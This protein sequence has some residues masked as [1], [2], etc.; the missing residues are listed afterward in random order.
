MGF[1]GDFTVGEVSEMDRKNIFWEMVIKVAALY[2][3]TYLE[4][5]SHE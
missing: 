2:E 5:G 1:T 4:M 3:I